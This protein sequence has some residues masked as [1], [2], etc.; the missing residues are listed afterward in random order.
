LAAFGAALIAGSIIATTPGLSDAGAD[1]LA[2][3]FIALAVGAGKGSGGF[4]LNA[5]AGGV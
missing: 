1:Y 5:T 4:G 3:F 2:R